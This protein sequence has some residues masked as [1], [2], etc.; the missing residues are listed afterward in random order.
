MM[1]KSSTLHFSSLLVNGSIA[2][3]LIVKKIIIID[4]T[5]K[6]FQQTCRLL[7][8]KLICYSII[9]NNIYNDILQTELEI[10]RTELAPFPLKQQ[11]QADSHFT[12]FHPP[13]I[14]SFEL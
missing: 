8:S 11:H 12:Y 1:A 2:F 7:L 6:W 10:K 14:G 9:Y 3:V 5:N 4:T 13:C